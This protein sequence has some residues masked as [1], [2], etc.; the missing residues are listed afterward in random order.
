MHKYICIC[1]YLYIYIFLPTQNANATPNLTPHTDVKH[2]PRAI[3]NNN[4][5][6]DSISQLENQLY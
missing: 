4:K 5:R 6:A 1:I 3:I 2:G